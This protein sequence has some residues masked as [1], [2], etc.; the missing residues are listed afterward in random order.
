M[1]AICR[2]PKGAAPGAIIG[3]GILITAFY[4]FASF[5]IG[6]GIPTA[7]LSKASGFIDSLRILAGSQGRA[8]RTDLWVV[9]LFTLV[10]NMLTWSL[11]QLC[12]AAR[13][14]VWHRCPNSLASKSKKEGM[15]LG[16]NLTNGAS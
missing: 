7:E 3:G 8:S 15:P 6:V 11:S 4:L 5:G 13:R 2:T 16:A 12:D 1:R 14:T 9:V 10:T